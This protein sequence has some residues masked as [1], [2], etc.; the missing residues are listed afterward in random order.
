MT[1]FTTNLEVIKSLWQRGF[2]AIP[3][4]SPSGRRTFCYGIGAWVPDPDWPLQRRFVVRARVGT[5][6]LVAWA[7]SPEAAAL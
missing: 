1:V 2:D 3:V 4:R 5:A 7:N 6:D